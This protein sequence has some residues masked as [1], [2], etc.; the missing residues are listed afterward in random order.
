MACNPSTV[1]ASVVVEGRICYTVGMDKLMT[2]WPVWAAVAL[3]LLVDGR[4]G[5]SLERSAYIR[6]ALNY[7]QG[8]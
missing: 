2:G 3:A 4:N 8:R 6:I 5:V 7:T 1:A